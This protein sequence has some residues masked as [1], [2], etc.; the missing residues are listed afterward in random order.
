MER[1]NI[2]YKVM[3]QRLKN[4]KIIILVITMSFLMG[5]VTPFIPVLEG[6]CVDRVIELKKT[7][8]EQ[9]YETRV[10][11]GFIGKQDYPMIRELLSTGEIEGHAWIEY[12]DKETGEW[13]RI[14]NL[15]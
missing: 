2:D 8:E 14:D 7:L 4:I 11:L 1:F 12:K 10:I 3:F 6:D 13:I 15:R 9:G 5:C